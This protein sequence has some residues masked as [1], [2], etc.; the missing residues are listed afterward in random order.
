MQIHSN[1]EK[2]TDSPFVIFAICWSLILSFC[3]NHLFYIFVKD[4]YNRCPI[5]LYFYNHP[6]FSYFS[7]PLLHYI[8]ELSI[9]RFGNVNISL[10]NSNL[11]FYIKISTKHFKAIALSSFNFFSPTLDECKSANSWQ[12]STIR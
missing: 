6:Y 3:A 5:F 1:T 4:H 10:Y 11:F 12:T 8:I 9:I 7:Q 2:L